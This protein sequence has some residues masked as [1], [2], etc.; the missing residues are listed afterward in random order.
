MKPPHP[1]IN[2]NIRYNQLLTPT[3]FHDY[4]VGYILDSDTEAMIN[5]LLFFRWLLFAY[6]Q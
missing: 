5:D 6:P 3:T 4:L 1:C 2:H